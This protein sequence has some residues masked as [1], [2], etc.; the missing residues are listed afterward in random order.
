MSELQLKVSEEK[1]LKKNNKD[2]IEEQFEYYLNEFE[3]LS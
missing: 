3:E 2:E 1:E